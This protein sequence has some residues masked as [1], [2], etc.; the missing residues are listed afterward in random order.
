MQDTKK[1]IQHKC[2]RRLLECILYSSCSYY[3][4]IGAHDHKIG[5][6]E[7]EIGLINLLIEHMQRWIYEAQI[8]EI[9]DENK[10]ASQVPFNSDNKWMAIVAENSINRVFMIPEV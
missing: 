2:T 5:G 9:L 4:L 1:L 6:Q 7:T 3:E 10:H 8:R